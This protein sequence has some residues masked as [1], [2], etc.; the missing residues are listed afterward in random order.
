MVSGSLFSM[1]LKI[2]NSLT[3]EKEEF[4]PLEAGSVKMYVCG[5]TVYD[6]PHIGHLRSAYVFETMRR[7][8]QSPMCGYKVFFVRNVT[9][10][11]D[12]IIEKARAQGAQADLIQA[13]SEV[14]KTYFDLYKRD[15]RRLGIFEPTQEPKATEHIAQMTDLINRLV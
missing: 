12:K 13:V 1:S 7:Y 6:E 14:S 8:L 2:T 15:L 10:V 4:R 5:P 3:Q 11:D 9:D